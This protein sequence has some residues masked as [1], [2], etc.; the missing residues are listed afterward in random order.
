MSMLLPCHFQRAL[1]VLAVDPTPRVVRRKP[2]EQRNRSNATCS[3]MQ[4]YKAIWVRVWTGEV[5]EVR[6]HWPQ[7]FVPGFGGPAQRTGPAGS[8]VTAMRPSAQ[9][10]LAAGTLARRMSKYD[11]I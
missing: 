4:R 6:R 8:A 10:G 1:E 5:V 11:R 2:T 9:G 3:Q 7:E